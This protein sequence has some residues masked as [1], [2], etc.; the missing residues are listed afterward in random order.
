MKGKRTSRFKN[1]LDEQQLY[2]FTNVNIVSEVIEGR[3]IACN[4]SL[5][6]ITFPTNIN[7]NTPVLKG[8]RFSVINIGFLNLKKQY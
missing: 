3:L 2:K 8:H 5:L 4:G 1:I 6:D 7:Y